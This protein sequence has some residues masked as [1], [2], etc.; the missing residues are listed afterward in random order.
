[1][2]NVGLQIKNLRNACMHPLSRISIQTQIAH[3]LQFVVKVTKFS[4][5]RAA[6]KIKDM[7]TGPHHVFGIK[8]GK[9]RILLI[10]FIQFYGLG[11]RIRD[12][13]AVWRLNGG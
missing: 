12:M 4:Y 6:G 7:R 10:L 8:V 9:N 2:Q 3:D 13:E 11:S 1:M 5:I